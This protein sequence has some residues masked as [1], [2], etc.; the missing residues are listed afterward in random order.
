MD[1]VETRKRETTMVTHESNARAARM[2]G[3]SLAE[4]EVK[5]EKTPMAKKAMAM[6]VVAVAMRR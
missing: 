6:A 4:T 2:E 1:R 5:R 3:G